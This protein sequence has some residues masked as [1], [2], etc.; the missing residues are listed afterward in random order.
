MME[1]VE[2]EP[3]QEPIQEQVMEYKGP[4][5]VKTQELTQELTQEQV[6]E[7][8]GP[9]EVK[10]QELTQELVMEMVSKERAEKI[11]GL[12]QELVMELVEMIEM[13][14]KEQAEKWIQALLEVREMEFRTSQITSLGPVFGRIPHVCYAHQ[15]Q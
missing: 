4:V 13:M 2:L 14:Y 3:I 8:K 15:E 10:T 9:V 6:M 7:Y 1:L 12:L 11:Q 5:E